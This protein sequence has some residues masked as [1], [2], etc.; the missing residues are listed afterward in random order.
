MQLAA[1]INVLCYEIIASFRIFPATSRNTLQQFITWKR[2]A[3][4][5]SM[6]LQNMAADEANILC[7]EIG[8]RARYVFRPDDYG[9]PAM[10]NTII[11]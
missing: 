8:E 6:E 11:M 7:Q 2:S 9:F 5:S 1:N 4:V 10:S 3:D